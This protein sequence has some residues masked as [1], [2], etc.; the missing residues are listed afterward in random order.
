MHPVRDGSTAVSGTY[1]P[2]VPRLTMKVLLHEE[3]LLHPVSHFDPAPANLS[4][5]ET[6]SVLGFRWWRPGN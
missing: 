2:G 6:E 1:T 3:W 4:D 5:F